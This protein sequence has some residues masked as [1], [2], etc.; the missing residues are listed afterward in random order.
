MTSD[1]RLIRCI[2]GPILLITLGVLMVVHQFTSVSF[3]R[4]W[5]VLVIVL[6]V[7]VLLE[8]LGPSTDS[9]VPPAAGPGPFPGVPGGN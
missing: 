6:G 3:S 5:P 7:M 9:A 4:L 8:R 2:R 1:P